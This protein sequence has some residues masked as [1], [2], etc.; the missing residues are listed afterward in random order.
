M[1]ISMPTI[2][3]SLYIADSFRQFH[4]FFD[5]LDQADPLVFDIAD[6]HDQTGGIGG[7]RDIFRQRITGKTRL[8]CRL[9]AQGFQGLLIIAE[10]PHR[11]RLHFLDQ[12]GHIS[13]PRGTVAPV[14]DQD[15]QLFLLAP[16]FLIVDHLRGADI[17]GGER[18]DKNGI[19]SLEHSERIGIADEAFDP[20]IGCFPL[21]A[22][23]F[24]DGKGKSDVFREIQRFRAGK[25]SQAV[26]VGDSQRTAELCGALPENFRKQ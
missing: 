23:R 19:V 4:F 22:K 6:R 13:C 21:C 9:P 15:H 17:I 20:F 24:A 12:T 16:S 14:V 25:I 18:I 7:E 11:S 10:D 5:P 26:R 1:A 8:R 2:T 3:I